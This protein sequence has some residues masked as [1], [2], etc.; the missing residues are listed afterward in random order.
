MG[1]VS[2][3]SMGTTEYSSSIS[4]ATVQALSQLTQADR[5]L[6]NFNNLLGVVTSN[7]SMKEA[8]SEA[9]SQLKQGFSDALGQFAV[10][11]MQVAAGIMAMSSAEDFLS[12][13][14]SGDEIDKEIMETQ[15]EL[16][17]IEKPGGGVALTDNATDEQIAERAAAQKDYDEQTQPLKDK[18][19]QLDKDKTSNNREQQR[20][21]GKMRRASGREGVV[22]GIGQMVQ[23]SSK[24]YSAIQMAKATIYRALAAMMVTQAQQFGSTAAHFASEMNEAPK[25]LTQMAQTVNS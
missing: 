1:L 13:M 8:V 15:N 16:D 18:L 10:G 17:A 9:S 6:A 2:Y 7:N 22:N 24:A 12:N 3:S 21:D 20:L 14:S 4:I 19:E 23:S 11:L 5:M 25:S